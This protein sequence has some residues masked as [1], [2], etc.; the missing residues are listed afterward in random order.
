MIPKGACK[1]QTNGGIWYLAE[2]Y[3]LG[4][5][6]QFTEEIL[7]IDSIFLRQ[8]GSIMPRK[9]RFLLY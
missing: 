8:E 5:K 2:K 3:A 7:V 9:S 4:H 1:A 6:R